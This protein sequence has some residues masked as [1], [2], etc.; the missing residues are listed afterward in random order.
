MAAETALKLSR[1][2]L[3]GVA[4]LT[5]DEIHRRVQGRYPEAQPLP[6]YPQLDP[7]MR[8][9]ELGFE[10]QAGS[11]GKP[12]CYQISTPTLGSTTF[13]GHAASSTHLPPVEADMGVDKFETMI[14]Q[15]LQQGRFLS[16]SVRSRHWQ[17]TR[18]QLCKQ[19][20]LTPVNF[21]EALFHHLQQYLDSLSRPPQWPTILRADSA[22]AGSTDRGRLERLVRAA[23]PALTEQ[24]LQS[25]QPVLLTQPGLLARYNLITTWL[26]EL[27]LTMAQHNKPLL[28]LIAT[29]ADH[30][31]AFI[32]GTPIPAGAGSAEYSRVPGAWLLPESAGSTKSTKYQ[33]E[34]RH[35]LSR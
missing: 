30:S 21:D 33:S 15:T 20:D 16:L 22:P 4:R 34:N 35:G 13:A 24:I 32:D 28:L 29:D 5:V 3:L 25:E 23:L 18:D 27:R 14:H 9:L 31:S 7:L 17:I 1:N 2:A 10:W 11:G 19:Y 12:G 8:K 26:A 6:G